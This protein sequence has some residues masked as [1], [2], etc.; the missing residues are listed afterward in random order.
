MRLSII[1]PILNEASGLPSML[2]SL[3]E[4]QRRQC[5]IILVDGGSKDDSVAIARSAG[6]KVIHAPR[7]RA[8][9]MN[10]GAAQARG[11]FFLF[12][13]ADTE[14][15]QGADRA[16]IEALDHDSR[17][18][19]RF[20]V[21]I[22]G[23][24]PMLK[25]IATMMNRRSS[26]TG[27]ATGDQAIFMRRSAFR[28]LNGFPA[29]DLMEDIEFSKR[30]KYLSLPICLRDQVLTSG[31]RWEVRGVWKTIFLMWRLRLAYWAGAKPEK[32]AKI[33]TQ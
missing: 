28:A 12:L 29:Q 6:F 30:A 11:D 19:G 23:S 21:R 7:G 16:V 27:I 4:F 14:L 5:E 33:Y 32:L 13:H 25:V 18:W 31:R 20:D 17:V 2:G 10:A 3:L 15:P 1:V 9:Q 26:W 24:S 22:V 8:A